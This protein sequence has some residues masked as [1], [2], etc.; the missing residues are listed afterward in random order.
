MYAHFV[1]STFFEGFQNSDP[2]KKHWFHK[3][4]PYQLYIEPS[5][6]PTRYLIN[7]VYF[8]LKFHPK[9]QPSGVFFVVPYQKNWFCRGPK[10]RTICP[11]T[12]LPRIFGLSSLGR[13]E[14]RRRPSVSPNRGTSMAQEVTSQTNGKKKQQNDVA[15]LS[16]ILLENK[17]ALDL[18]SNMALDIY[19]NGAANESQIYLI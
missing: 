19:H 6:N 12:G 16:N 11:N 17:R 9:N 14:I 3:M 13:G 2:K 18:L 10:I 4:G 5:K 1:P 8:S 15:A 7:G